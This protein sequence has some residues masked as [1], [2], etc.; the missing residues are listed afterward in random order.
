[1]HKLKV[2]VFIAFS[3]NSILALSAVDRN[4]KSPSSN[5]NLLAQLA[6][7]KQWTRVAPVTRVDTNLSFAVPFPSLAG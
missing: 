7:Y 2:F 5:K 1:M 4:D 6:R 3:I